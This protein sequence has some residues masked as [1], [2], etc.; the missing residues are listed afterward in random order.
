M[1]FIDVLVMFTRFQPPTNEWIPKL[2][3]RFLASSRC[4]LFLPNRIKNMVRGPLLR[5][6]LAV[7]AGNLAIVFLFL[8]FAALAQ[9]VQ[10]APAPR[11]S[12]VVLT[13]TV[14]ITHTNNTTHEMSVF[15]NGQLTDQFLTFDGVSSSNRID[16]DGQDRAATTIAV[17]FDQHAS[18]GNSVDVAAQG[19]FEPTGPITLETNSTLPGISEDTQAIYAS[20]VLS[21]Q[22]TQRTLAVTAT[23]CVIIEFDVLN[24]GGIPLTNGRFLFMVDADA[25]LFE[26]G[27]VGQFD[28]PRR[29]AYLSDLNFSAGTL[30]GYAVG[31]S[32]LRGDYRGF[33]V[34]GDDSRFPT[35]N[36]PAM[37][38]YPTL[39]A[40]ISNE[41]NTPLNVVDNDPDS[42]HV[43]W[44]VVNLPDLGPGQET[45]LAFSFCAINGVDQADAEDNFID[46]HEDL[47]SLSIV[48]TASPPSGNTVVTGDLITYTITLTNTGDLT[49]H[50]VVV[51]DIIPISTSIVALNVSQGMITAADRLVTAT[52]GQLSPAGGPVTINIVVLPSPN[53]PD[54]TIMTNQAFLESDPLLTTT[55]IVTHEFARPVLNITKQS[56]PQP[57]PT[58]G[59]LTYTIVISNGGQIDAVGAVVSDTL[60]AGTALVGGINLQP[61][62]AGTIGTPPTLVDNLT[63][64]SG[65]RVTITFVVALSS[66]LPGGSVITNTASI[67][68][69]QIPMPE[70]S[71]ITNSVE[72]RS[73]AQIVKTGP[74]TANVG[75]TVSFTFTVTN[76]GNT[77]LQ[78]VEVEDNV[79][80]TA[81]LISG[82]ANGNSELDL[83][84]TW[85][86][87]ANYTIPP[88]TADPLTNTVTVTGVGVIGGQL[89]VATDTHTTLIGFSPVLSLTKQGP[90]T[91]NVGTPIVYTFTL[92]HA[93]NSDGSPVAN[94]TV[95]DDVAGVATLVSGDDGDNQLEANE[96][97]IFTVTYT[98]V[99][100]DPSPLINTGLAQGQDRDGGVIT[101]TASHSTILKKFNPLLRLVKTG[102][103]SANVNQTV[104][105]TFTI[106]HAPGSDGSV[107]S[108]LMVNDSVAGPVTQFSGDDGDNLLEVS[109]TWIYTASYTIKPTDPTPLQN[110][111]T[112]TGRDGDGDLIIGSDTHT[113]TLTGFAPVLFVDKDGP[114]RANISDTVVYTFTVINYVELCSLA[115]FDIDLDLAVLATLEPGDGSPISIASVT[116]SLAGAATYVSGDI[117]PTNGLLDGC[118]GWVYT[119]T[120]TIGSATPDPV[121]NVATVQGR[122]RENDL[123]EATAQHSTAIGPFIP[124]PGPYRY[125]FPLIIK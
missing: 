100:S 114:T 96:S 42:N 69:P 65:E 5:L 110:I 109:E 54:G 8:L 113:T 91:A 34:N 39:D 124:P 123:L 59:L 47:V 55:N 82:D 38:S 103:A 101:A 10:A 27:D 61:G 67:T 15:A 111:A 106:S 118:E 79:A 24:T 81:N 72:I 121:V 95:D 2:L 50:N 33:G 11:P 17:R 80:G 89:A 90:I 97:W 52:L 86:Y 16:R 21:Y 32:L 98:P 45:P 28:E 19:E 87:T 66:A 112:V 102:P 18:T 107:V 94:V 73:D 44:F 93:G 77:A 20:R 78:N 4:L 76:L 122:D 92:S 85:V 70:S 105:F 40:D 49:L 60:P 119:A 83:T 46:I 7:V 31:A 75:N 99:I 68:A 63:I 62:G 115:K 41:M 51:T 22:V 9:D 14:L 58:G 116:D 37:E 3:K 23:N 26:Y 64:G 1:K 48:K 84:E 13:G 36:P 125:L 12:A 35:T 108:N 104:I 56:T 43:I 88:T 71:T 30:F 57:V 25:G 29:L 74:A 120:Y 117:G 53:I 6:G